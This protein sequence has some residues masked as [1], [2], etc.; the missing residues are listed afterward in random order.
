MFVPNLHER[1][2]PAGGAASAARRCSPTL[3]IVTVTDA[4]TDTDTDTDARTAD[5]TLRMAQ[6]NSA[7]PCAAGR[8]TISLTSTSAGCSIANA[9]A[10]AIATGGTA[11]LSRASMS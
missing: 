5:G 6:L 11:N 7:Q 8:T 9:M 4:D 2:R 1:A 3:F 10:R